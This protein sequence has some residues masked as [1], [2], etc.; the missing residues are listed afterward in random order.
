MNRWWAGQPGEQYWLETTD[1]ND[2]GANL[3]APQTDHSGRDNWR[4]SLIRESRIGDVIF[5]Y[6]KEAQSILAHSRV[7]S[8]VYSSDIV[9]AARG[10][11]ARLKTPT[12]GITTWLAA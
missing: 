2:L 9:W 8:D 3:H 11:Y 5:H 10:S 12:T 1:R 4:Y 6:H 7:A